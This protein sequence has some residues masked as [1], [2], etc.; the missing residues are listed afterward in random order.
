MSSFS[1]VVQCGVCGDA[2]K[3]AA[4][5]WRGTLCDGILT[6]VRGTGVAA[7]GASLRASASGAGV[8]D[9]CSTSEA[10]SRVTKRCVSGDGRTG[11][12]KTTR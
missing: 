1:E 5:V 11:K 9:G 4:G 12:N 10:S 2:C 3:V 7:E 6:T 8:V